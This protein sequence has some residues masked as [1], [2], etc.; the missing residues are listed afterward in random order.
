MILDP[1]LTMTLWRKNKAFILEYFHI[2][3]N[4]MIQAFFK[5]ANEFN[6]T[7]TNEN[8]DPALEPLA[9]AS[10]STAPK[11]DQDFFLSEF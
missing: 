7:I 9:T 10:T 3:H 4:N 8:E 6:C 2:S 5:A 1:T 11:Q